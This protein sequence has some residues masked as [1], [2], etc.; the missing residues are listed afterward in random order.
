MPL[1]PGGVAR[2]VVACLPAACRPAMSGAASGQVRRVA[3]AA[4]R[5]Y[6]RG[7]AFA[8]VLPDYVVIGGQRCGTTSLFRY[9]VR[10]SLIASAGEKEIHFFDLNHA[11]GVN[12][13]RA[14]FPLEARMKSRDGR[15]RLLTGEATPYYV[16]HPHVAR[17]MRAL[18]PDAKLIVLLRDPVERAY[19]HYRNEVRIGT[20]LLSFEDAIAREEERVGPELERMMVDE[21]YESFNHRHFSYLSRGLY[22]DQLERWWAVFPREQIK[23]IASEDLFTKPGDV[24]DEVVA[25]LDLPAERLADYPQWNAQQEGA[26]RSDTRKRLTEYFSEPNR[27]LSERLGRDLGW[28]S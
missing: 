6:R 7:T 17:R 27:H 24:V 28:R 5:V 2:E 15:C 20:E 25:F 3:R 18:I 1:R 10:H 23:V 9:L 26:I 13:Y 12:W 4:R 8:R 22:L 11:K 14:H 21:R 16:F 19:S